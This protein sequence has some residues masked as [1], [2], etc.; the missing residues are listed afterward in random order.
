MQVNLHEPKTCVVLYRRPNMKIPQGV[1]LRYPGHVVPLCCMQQRAGLL[2][3]ADALAASGS[4]AMQAILGR[5]PLQ[6]IT[7]FDMKCRIFDRLAEPV[8]SYGSLI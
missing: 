6:S 3:A 4:R 1:D 8:M 5:C 7:Q 2:A